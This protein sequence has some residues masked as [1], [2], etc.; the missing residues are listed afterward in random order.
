MYLNKFNQYKIPI[1]SESVHDWIQSYYKYKN[2]L[3]YADSV[4]DIIKNLSDYN[5]IILHKPLSNQQLILFL[6]ELG[7]RK[8][9]IESRNNLTRLDIRFV[10]GLIIIIGVNTTWG[11]TL[12]GFKKLLFQL[13]YHG[14][15]VDYMKF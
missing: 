2:R 1:E 5:N 8:I 3:T 11:I 6:Q 7:I 12:T 9:T 13:F 14:Y 15:L 10:S 4:N